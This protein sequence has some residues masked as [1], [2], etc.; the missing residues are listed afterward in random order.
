[1][2]VRECSQF[3]EP[4]VPVVIGAA[5]YGIKASARRRKTCHFADVTIVTLQDFYDHM[6]AVQIKLK[7]D[8]ALRVFQSHL[9]W[10]PNRVLT[11]KM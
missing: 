2:H 3:Y 9:L 1:M 6:E 7:K 8:K 10:S 5:R 4:K 11:P